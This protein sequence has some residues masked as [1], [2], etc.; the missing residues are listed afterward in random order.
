[1]ETMIEFTHASKQFTVKVVHD[2]KA[3]FYYWVLLSYPE[4]KRVFGED[5][6]FYKPDGHL[7]PVDLT[8]R[9]RNP[10]LFDDIQKAVED[11]GFK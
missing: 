9:T 5:L 8:L 1:M 3:P 6:A 4:L 11:A 2:G 7:V 10:V